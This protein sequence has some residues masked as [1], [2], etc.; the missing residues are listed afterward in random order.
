MEDQTGTAAAGPRRSRRRLLAG[1][2]AGLGVLTAEALARPAPASAADGDPVILGQL[3][4]ETGGTSITNSTSG[5]T[6]FDC[7]AIGSGNAVVGNSETG[8]GVQGFTNS[9][10]GVTGES[11]SGRGVY[12][13][14]GN[15][16]SSFG[17]ISNGVHG[18]TDSATGVGVLGENA[19][20]GT[21][22]GGISTTSDGV[23]GTSTSGTGAHGVSST[24]IGVLGECPSGTGVRATGKTALSVQGPT[25][26]SRS[27]TLTVAAG[28]SSATKT[29]VTLTAASLVL[30]TL[31]QDR[32][33]VWVRSAVP[34][35]AASS[36]TVHLSKAV[37]AS[38][39]VAWFIL[40]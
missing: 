35:V 1:A 18:V 29:G 32:A 4:T 30:A 12:G 25:V 33:G 9:G 28:A 40:N 19:D 21:A 11:V 23:G 5:A 17:S 14:S 27:G 13:Q 8:D 16:G 31:Q 38:T 37:S 39:G 34:N 7:T 26:F 10:N 6:A 22:V 20:G 24:G 2:A 36:F 3:N 15:T